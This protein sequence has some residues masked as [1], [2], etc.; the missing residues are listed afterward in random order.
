MKTKDDRG[1]CNLVACDSNIGIQKIPY[2]M[3]LMQAAGF[4]LGYRYSVRFD[5]VKSHGLISSLGDMV[6]LGYITNKYTLTDRGVEEL[7]HYFLTNADCGLCDEVLSYVESFDLDQLYL[8]C[9][10]DIIVCD[11]LNTGG[12]DSLIRDKEEIIKMVKNLC[13]N[14]SYEDFNYSIGVFRKLRKGN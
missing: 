8:L 4:E 7:N 5:K 1:F 10:T 6:S 2:F 3:Y 14:F 11:A 12:C 13:T 9:V